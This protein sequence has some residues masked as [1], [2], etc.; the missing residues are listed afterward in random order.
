[1][2]AAFVQTAALA[3]ALGEHFALELSD[4]SKHVQLEL[5]D[6]VRRLGERPED[7]I[8]RTQ[9]KIAAGSCDQKRT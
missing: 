3:R 4:R 1:V 5:R 6:G 2:E 7:T 9:R 8:G